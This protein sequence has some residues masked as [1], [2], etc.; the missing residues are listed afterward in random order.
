MSVYQGEEE[1]PL[2]KSV[3]LTAA[4]VLRNLA[5][6]SALAR[7]WVTVNSQFYP[8]TSHEKDKQI[9]Y[10]K[11]KNP[12]HIHTNSA[13]NDSQFISKQ[14][15]LMNRNINCLFMYWIVVMV[16]HSGLDFRRSLVSGPF[17]E[18]SAGSFPEQ[19]LVMEPFNCK[20][21]SWC[22]CRQIQNSWFLL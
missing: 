13:G 3:R 17:L 15:I 14:Q 16:A 12:Y 5:Q 10:G 6:Y 9:G 18:S 11:I 7:R 8:T 1:S 2:T 20:P 21:V 22:F 19:R 4:L